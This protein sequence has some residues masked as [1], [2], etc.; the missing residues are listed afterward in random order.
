MYVYIYNICYLSFFSF[1]VVSLIAFT[2]SVWLLF[3][4]EMSH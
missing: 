3:R 1:I 2:V 4:V